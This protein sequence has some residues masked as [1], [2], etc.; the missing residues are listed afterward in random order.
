MDNRVRPYGYR[1]ASGPLSIESAEE[2]LLR[3]LFDLVDTQGIKHAV[4]V[5]NDGKKR[6]SLKATYVLQS[7]TG[8]DE[9]VSEKEF[10]LA[11]RRMFIRGLKR[12]N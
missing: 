5:L 7:P 3:R 6:S 12:P 11:L 1:P 2:G 4:D 10:M 8:D 9:E